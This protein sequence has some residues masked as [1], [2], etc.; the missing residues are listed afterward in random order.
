MRFKIFFL[1]SVILVLTTLTSAD[2]KQDLLDLINQERASVGVPPLVNH[3]TIEIA[4]Q[5]HSQDMMDNSYFSHTSL[6]GRL[7]WDRM[8]AAGFYGTAYGENIAAHTGTPD[9]QLVFDLWKNSPGHY[10]NMINPNFNVGGIGIITDSWGYYGG[11]TST[12]YTHNLGRTNL[13]CAN[14]DTRQ[15]GSSN[16]GRCEYGTQTCSNNQ[17]QSCIGNIE[18]ITEICDNGIDDDCDGQTD[19]NCNCQSHT[20]FSCYNGD[21][22]W[23]DSC[24]QR[25]DRKEDCVDG[26]EDG[27]CLVCEEHTYIGC[28]YG[29]VYWYDSCER[30]EERKED[31][32]DGCSQG[33]CITCED[34]YYAGCYRNDAYWYDS[35]GRRQEKKEDC[36]LGCEEGSCT[37]LCLDIEICNEVDDNCNE[38]IDEDCIDNMVLI[39]PEE[40]EFD[41]RRVRI[42]LDIADENSEIEYLRRGRWTRF[43]SRPTNCYKTLSLDQGDNIIEIR[44][45]D[46]SG[47]ETEM[48]LEVFVDS[49]KPK[50]QKQTPRNRKYGNGIFTAKYTEDNPEELI[51]YI[52][53]EPVITKED[54][55]PG[56][57]QECTIEYD[58]GEYEGQEIEYYF[59]LKD[60][61]NSDDRKPYTIKIDTTPPEITIDSF[62]RTSEKYY[63]YEAEIIVDED[64]RL[65][66]NYPGLRRP[67]RICSKC[68]EKTKKFS[69]RNLPDHIEVIAT[70]PAGNTDIEVIEL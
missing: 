32:V 5:L 24:N 39:N 6:D 30:R 22:Y 15:C 56:R 33:Q 36:E 3:P 16:E 57:N 26:C 59:E 42:E 20:T 54:C 37:Q 29:D 58:I 13:V 64:V 25:Q 63:R 70:D 1:I 38:Q 48:I 45:T 52:N 35:C 12:I 41:T 55:L 21:V 19:E 34:H 53:N 62:E 4:A 7:P 47:F 65:E 18:P 66:Y 2:T 46:Y 49:K 69:F 67:R 60:R 11:M 14:G 28:Y 10:S 50:L 27:E 61:F 44:S 40:K 9:P 43:C 23:Y 68:D 51:L 8:Q 17:W 31:C